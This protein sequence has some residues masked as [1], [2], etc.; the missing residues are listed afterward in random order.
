[1][2]TR[3]SYWKR[4]NVEQL[5]A[6]VNEKTNAELAEVFASDVDTIKNVMKRYRIQRSPEAIKTLISNTGEKNPN[7]KGGIQNDNYRYKKIQVERYPEKVAARNAVYAAIKSGKLVP[8]PC[9]VCGATEDV[10]GHHDDYT[11]KLDVR[12]LCRKHH[13]EVHGGTH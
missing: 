11:K 10:H 13:R 7:W 4:A 6:L 3:K 5:R 2:R 9:E 12:W 8:Q 1:M